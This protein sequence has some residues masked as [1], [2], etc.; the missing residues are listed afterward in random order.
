MKTSASFLFISAMLV[1]SIASAHMHDE[2]DSASSDQFPEFVINPQV[3][4]NPWTNLL[5]NNDAENFQIAIVTDRTGGMRPGVFADAVNKLNLL[6]PEFVMSVGDLIQGYTQDLNQLTYEWDEFDNLV[7][8]LEMPFFYVAGNH[9]YTNPVMAEVWKK[10]Y[11]KSYYHFTYR[12]VLFVVLNSNDANKPHHMT[13]TQIDWLEGVLKENPDPRWTLVFIHAPLWDRKDENL[14]PEAEAL[15]EGRKYT[16]FAGHNHRYVKH[17]RKNSNYYTLATTGGGSGLRGERFGEFDHVVWLTMTEEGPLLA[18]LLLEGIWD[19]NIRTEETRTLQEKL[20]D[21]GNLSLQPIL[22]REHFNS[23]TTELH[24]T[25]DSN[26]PYELDLDLK[27]VSN[28]SLRSDFS[29]HLTIAPNEVEKILVQVDSKENIHSDQCLLEMSWNMKFTLQGTQVEYEGVEPLVAVKELPVSI[30][31]SIQVDGSLA[32]WASL[33]YHND[34]EIIQLQVENWKSPKDSGFSW[35]IGCDE[36]KLYMGIRVIDDDISTNPGDASWVQDSVNISIDARPNQLRNA[37]K[38]LG[39][40]GKVFAFFSLTPAMLAEETGNTY[41]E[42]IPEGSEFAAVIDETG[43]TVEISIPFSALDKM[44]AGSWSGL[45]INIIQTDRD[46]G[47]IGACAQLWKQAW[48]AKES[49]P[50]SGSFYRQIS[51]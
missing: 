20:I 49:L 39:G 28:V 3:G 48:S 26:I 33:P 38:T 4:Q 44:A 2:H 40:K 42:G 32:D 23:G 17:V 8:Q 14:W 37:N 34:P 18:N 27:L 45:R 16:V 30:I 6:Q 31:D 47:E 7:K 43:Y 36:Q 19:D 5:L 11:G 15:L 12:D 10:R 35:N 51:K 41:A 13:Q 25:N 46:A 22:F 24:L 21:S 1:M 9:D 29:H 50:G